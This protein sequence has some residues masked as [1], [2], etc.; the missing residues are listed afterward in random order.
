MAPGIRCRV[1]GV[2]GYDVEL[3]L[4]AE[5]GAHEVDEHV[6][7]LA[8][9]VATDEEKAQAG[10]GLGNAR[11]FPLIQVDTWRDDADASV[12]DTLRNGDL[13]RPNATTE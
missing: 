7:A 3:K 8:D 6:T 12:C 10:P 2:A 5:W 11:P 13:R 9:E 4:L 1:D